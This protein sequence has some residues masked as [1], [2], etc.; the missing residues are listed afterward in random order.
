MSKNQIMS[1]EQLDRLA[2]SDEYAIYIMGNCGGDRVIADGDTL[3]TAMEDGYLWEEFLV[4]LGK[5]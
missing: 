2:V 3:I 5:E 4:S 1:D